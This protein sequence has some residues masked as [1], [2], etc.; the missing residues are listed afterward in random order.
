MLGPRREG[1]VI[2]NPDDVI[3]VVSVME[4]DDGNPMVARGL[5]KAS[6][7]SSLA[8]SKGMDR[9]TRVG[10]LI[11]DINSALKMP[12]GAPNFDDLVGTKELRL[13]ASDLQKANAGLHA[14]NLLFTGDGGQYRLRF[15][16][17]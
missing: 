13:K 3:L 4:N 11:N 15:E 7:V 6:A 8:A 16:L 10:Q 12:T 9:P 5:V 17:S 14:I 2:A 1:R